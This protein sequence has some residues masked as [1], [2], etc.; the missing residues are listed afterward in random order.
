MCGFYFFRF[1]Q[2]LKDDPHFL[3]KKVKEYLQ[4]NPHHLTLIMQPNSL[5]EELIKGKEA[6]LLAAK[7]KDVDEARREQLAREAE[8]LLEEQNKKPDVSVLPTLKISD[9]EKS[10]PG[11][12]I[13]RVQFN[14][15]P[16]Q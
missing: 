3:Q 4:D 7:T 1:R 13:E 9:I 16:V 10:L 2:T 14:H 12:D 11:S 5:Y 15:T 8:E 6:E